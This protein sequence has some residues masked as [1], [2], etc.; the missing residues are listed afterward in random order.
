MEKFDG[1]RKQPKLLPPHCRHSVYVDIRVKARRFSCNS[2]ASL[3]AHAEEA[4]VGQCWQVHV[5]PAALSPAGA[6][7]SGRDATSPCL[8][9]GRRA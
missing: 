3:P 5:D 6:N 2:K 4:V 1:E 7:L 8:V 9:L